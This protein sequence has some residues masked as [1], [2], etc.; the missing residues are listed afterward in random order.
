MP[1]IIFDMDDTLFAT[2]DLWL[3]A[4]TRL[5]ESLGARHIE[6]LA[7]QYKGMNALDV[8]ATIHRILQP[9]VSVQECQRRM[10]TELLLAFRK[11]PP[12]QMPGAIDCVTRMAR[13]TTI[14][15][16][17]G[18]PLE[19]IESVTRRLG[20]RD[21][22]AVVLSSESVKRGK[23]HPDVFLAAAEKLAV[24]PQQCLVFE[25]SLI[26]I[27]AALAAGMRVFAIPSGNH[28]A[29]AKKATRT[30]ASLDQITWPDIAAL[31]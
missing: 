6:E 14:A 27:E 28:A 1:A 16:A 25:D 13:H 8:A 24:P 12:G 21:H 18:S 26:G 11:S 30:Y 23:P 15:L 4:E 20:I 9:D 10:R 5:L 31:D 17:S 19:A 22:F 29:I 7:I 3:R 2:A